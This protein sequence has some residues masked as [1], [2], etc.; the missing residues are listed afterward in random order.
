VDR[1]IGFLKRVRAVVR[2]RTVDRE[3]AEEM[4]S[5]LEME[6]ARNID[7]GFPPDEA[8]R[9]AR[10]VFGSRDAAL[11]AHRDVRGGRWI[12]DAFADAR[13]AARTLRSNPALTAAAV[14]TIALGVGANT[15]IFSTLYAVVLRPLPYQDANRLVMVWESNAERGWVNAD[16]A[17]ANY[18]D[19]REQV[20]A[21]QDVAAYPTYE[22]ATVLRVGGESRLL[23]SMTVTGNFFSVLGV[24]PAV[25]RA[26][27]VDETWDTGERLAM[28][29]ERLWRNWFSADPSVVDRTV[30]LGGYPVRV[31]G[32]V[33][34]SFVFPGRDPDVWRPTA[35]AR[36][37]AQTVSFRRAHWLGVIARLKPGVT[38]EQADAELQVVVSRLQREYP[39]TN[40]GM[41]AGFTPLHRFLVGDVRQPLMALQVA[42]GLLLLIACANVGNL[43]LVRAADRERESVVRL[44]LG[45][46]RGR[47]VR[48]AFTESLVLS[49][50]GG[51]AG[52]AVGWI[53]TRILAARQ[54]EDMLPVGDIGMNAT[55][56]AFALAVTIGAGLLF[57][58][59]P[60]VWARRRDPAEVLKDNARTGSRSRVRRWSHGLA[61]AELAVA[62]ILM[63]GAG[64]LVRSWWRVQGV[65]SGI[66]PRGVL[67]ASL[68]MPPGRF[69]T[70]EGRQQFLD[71]VLDRLR[72]IPGVEYAGAV[73][74]LPVTLPAWSS[75]FS[76]AGRERE[77]YGVQVLHRE[78]TPEYHRVMGVPLLAGRW[79]TAADD[80]QSPLVVLINEALARKYFPNEN[81]IGRRVA[82]DRY[83]DSTSF[84]R[85]IV[86]VVGSERQHGLEREASPEF[87]APV[88]QDEP[89]SQVIVLRTT[90]E[91]TTVA[92]AVRSVVAEVNS[93][94]AINQV[95]PM[96]EI[97]DAALARRR[98]TMTLVLTFAGAGLLMALVGVYGVTA[99]LARGRRRELGIRMALGASSSG[100]QLLVVRRGMVLAVAGITIGMAAV[101]AATRGIS[102]LL[103]EVGPTDPLTLTVV[104]V[105]LSAAVL[106]ASWAPARRAA[107]TDPMET[108][109]VE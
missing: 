88:T 47:L 89:G 52:V 32:V 16:A 27:T 70:A 74:R 94:V 43:L 58:I 11:E 91:P 36:E 3:L 6:T 18:L 97:R 62:V 19:W 104:A 42:V 101:A 93:S 73:S 92:S 22:G 33:P 86:G 77:S 29:S 25:G 90:L 106:A 108:L 64:L 46:G 35:F 67:T 102:V 53:G 55:V 105:L 103:F 63:A 38:V 95:R 69:P 51:S 26:F 34:S 49:V 96:M 84:W 28:I 59:G 107:R 48:Q 21:F 76:V 40:T 12:A 56:L 9:R 83:P 68:S 72:A 24:K 99:Q 4:R 13:Y 15:A 81:P 20:G 57:G 61:V 39:I 41:G 23:T 85:T 87:F 7:A 75:D 1:V 5:H 10:A 45:A 100:I 82:F 44:A 80:A 65:D 78:V 30:E 79:F 14:V 31:V 109:R 2:R 60:A 8:S 66:D 37:Q 54:P 71:G 98:F 17:P 50:A